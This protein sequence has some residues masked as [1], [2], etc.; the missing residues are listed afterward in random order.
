MLELKQMAAI[1]YYSSFCE[2]S[3]KLLQ[4]L[5]KTQMNND[6]HFICIDKRVKGNDGKLYVVLESGQKIVM[7]ESVTKVPALLLLSD[8]YRVLYGDSIYNHLRPKQDAITKVATANNMEPLAFSLGSVCSDQYSF[9][10]MGSEELEAKG[11]GGLRQMH[12]Y[13]SLNYSDNITSTPS[14]DHD[15]K[16]PKSGPDMTVEKLQAKRDEEFSV[17]AK[18]QQRI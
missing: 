12:N 8:N 6:F 9:L 14:D 13:V 15:Y 10:D 4:T 17:F 7:P 16:A 3:K 1:L 18:Q 5:S 2:H 11:D